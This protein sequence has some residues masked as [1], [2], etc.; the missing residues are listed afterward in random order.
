MSDIFLSYA[1]EDRQ[2]IIPLVRALQRHGWSVWWDRTIPPGRIFA[3]VIEEAIN[4]A[5][6]VLVVW[7]EA[8]V[9]SAW[10]LEEAQEGRERSFLFPVL[11]DEVRPPFGFRHIQA[12][13]LLDWQETASHAEFDT[14]VQAIQA[15]I[16]PPAQREPVATDA[17]TASI[18]QRQ[19]PARGQESSPPAGTVETRM[20]NSLDMPFVLIPAGEF[21]MGSADGDDDEHPV[22]TVRISQPFYLG[23]YAVT[24]TQWQA[25]MGSNPSQFTGDLN[26][27]VESVSWEDAQ[28]FIRRLH[29]REDGATYRLPTEAEWEYAARA[30]ST[31]AYSFGD[32][33]RQLSEYAWYS[34]NSG[35]QTHP[36]GQLKPSAWGL[37]D[38]HGNVWEWVQDWYGP[39]TAAA[40]VDPA[41]PPSGSGRVIRGGSWRGGAGGCRS[42]Y[43][44]HAAPGF[45]FG[46]LGFRLLRLVS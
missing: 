29:A 20:V 5:Q 43:R 39:Y 8:S 26:R 24:Q 28:E 40:V 11:F 13:R 12:A 34:E 46:F 16:G 33:P 17:G 22:H 1:S 6:C 30:G 25:V 38:M 36:V 35:G 42:A 10:V 15:R 37:Y 41:G 31:T 32:D 27:P 21:L 3:Q 44:G 18:P 9:V 7:S 2:R 19:A 23:Q 14:L 45:R 4:A